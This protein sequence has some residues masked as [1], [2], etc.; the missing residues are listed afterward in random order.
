MQHRRLTK[1]LIFK[2]V[3][4]PVLTF[5]F[6]MEAGGIP[7]EGKDK[8]TEKNQDGSIPTVI[9]NILRQARF[10]YY[11]Q[12]DLQK[13]DSLHATAMKQAE[14][15]YKTDII[16]KVL[17]EYFAMNELGFVNQK[18][19]E[20]ASRAE[21][22]V[23]QLDDPLQEWQTYLNLSTVYLDQF[24]FDK[25]LNYCYKSLSIAEN[26]QDQNLKIRSFLRIGQVLQENNQPIE[27]FRFML[28]ALH[29]SESIKSKEHLILCYKALSRFYDLTR[30]YEKAISY[31][32]KEIDL[33][34]E[35]QPVDSLALIWSW[36][37]LEEI[38]NNSVNTL[39]EDKI[40]EIISFSIRH[41]NTYLKQYVLAMF[42][43][44]LMN[45]NLFERMRLFYEIT[46]P[47]EL[48]YLRIH[49]PAAYY[50]TRAV[51]FELDG[52]Q[53]SALYCYQQAEMLLRENPNKVLVSSFYIRY[54]EYLQRTGAVEDATGKFRKAFNQADSAGF[55]K[56]ALKACNALVG[57]LSSQ[58][59][60]EEALQ[61]SEKGKSIADSL[62]KMNRQDEMLALEIQ[63]TEQI[64]LMALR[65]ENLAATRKHNIQYSLIL[66]ILLATFMLLL[67][68][69]SV[70]VSARLIHFTG[71]FSFIFLFEFIILI[72][73]HYIHDITHGEPLKIMGIKIILIGILL[74]LHHYV[75]KKATHF[76]IHKK[77]LSFQKTT[78]RRML[79][80]IRATAREI[81][82]KWD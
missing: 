56:Y 34:T 62:A 40:C 45:N 25:A 77:L 73:D 14:M 71:F 5:L 6:V 13:A 80:G 75:E 19:M 63:N 59:L 55:F 12:G 70:R 24:Q 58:N 50:R 61:Y 15:T 44:Y 31:K 64:R 47:E 72:A 20:F 35:H 53:D 54:G 32:M 27:G 11:Q 17:N 43:T 21:E 38:S 42:R 36:C 66:L 22:I 1:L 60:F 16:L 46:Y 57:L 82:A 48:D 81:W 33:I 37:D 9:T 26:L 29:L 74:P 65:E 18:T 30:G 28:N 3:L 67:L 8:H 52:R 68:L 2:L 49:Q 79:A 23:I 10:A 39:H 69:G 78:F 76:L 4:L 41:Q 51:F 7:S